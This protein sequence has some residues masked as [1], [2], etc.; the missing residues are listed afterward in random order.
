MVSAVEDLG[1]LDQVELAALSGVL[2]GNVDVLAPQGVANVLVAVGDLDGLGGVGREDAVGARDVAEDDLERDV[3]EELDRAGGPAVPVGALARDRGRGELLL[4]P[5]VDRLESPVEVVALERG[6]ACR[7]VAEHLAVELGD[8]ELGE[9]ALLAC[10]CGV[11]QGLALGAVAEVERGGELEAVG[12]DRERVERAE[13]VEVEGVAR[14]LGGVVAVVVGVGEPGVDAEELLEGL[15]VLSGDRLGE[16][17]AQLGVGR[18]GGRVVPGELVVVAGVKVDARGA[19]GVGRREL[20]A[21]ENGVAVGLVA[22]RDATGPRLVRRGRGADVVERHEAMEVVKRR[23]RLVLRTRVLLDELAAP[24]KGVG[25]EGGRGGVEDGGAQVE[26]VVVGREPDAGLVGGEERPEDLVDDAEHERRARA[27]DRHVAL[28]VV[29]A[30]LEA[31]EHGEPVR[32]VHAREREDAA[33]VVPHAPVLDRDLVHPRVP[34]EPDQLEEVLSRQHVLPASRRAPVR[35]LAPGRVPDVLVLAHPVGLPLQ[36]RPGPQQQRLE[37]VH[38]HDLIPHHH[39]RRQSPARRQHQAQAAPWKPTRSRAHLPETHRQHRLHLRPGPAPTQ[40]PGR[41]PRRR[42]LLLRLHLHRFSP[43]PASRPRPT[44]L[45]SR[46]SH[47][48][49]PRHATF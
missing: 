18:V 6:R 14:R 19:G 32:L 29:D 20:A 27:E 7:R 38:V 47:L 45:A 31:V 37:Q 39:P 16:E 30:L 1:V 26:A 11:E 35:R 42:R 24:A 49:R 44:D 13:R 23:E 10:V 48:W 41:R 25:V 15:A 17:R 3:L 34:V 28:V 21:A 12:A 8:G 22:Q 5:D 33:R 40:R 36:P 4:V 43:S 2:G 46:P 9:V